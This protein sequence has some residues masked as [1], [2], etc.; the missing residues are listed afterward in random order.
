VARDR[1]CVASHRAL[2]QQP[3]PGQPRPTQTPGLVCG[4]YDVGHDSAFRRNDETA[5][6]TAVTVAK[7]VNRAAPFFTARGLY[8]LVNATTPAFTAGFRYAVAVAV[9]VTFS[10]TRCHFFL[11]WKIPTSLPP[12]F[13]KV[14]WVLHARCVPDRRYQLILRHARRLHL[15]GSRDIQEFGFRVLGQSVRHVKL[16]VR[17]QRTRCIPCEDL[18]DALSIADCMIGRSGSLLGFV[19]SN[20]DLSMG[21]IGDF[22]GPRSHLGESRRQWLLNAP[23]NWLSVIPANL[24]VQKLREREIQRPGRLPPRRKSIAR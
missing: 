8:A 12:V 2:R 14:S 3:H 24:P 6:L 20:P 4:S 1:L 7:P 23:E 16:C 19:G 9:A 21:L 18:F 5:A 22:V 10:A 17:L 13:W 11:R 15:D